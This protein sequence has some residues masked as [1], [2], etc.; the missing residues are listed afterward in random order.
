MSKTKSKTTEAER[1][2][3]VLSWFDG[4]DLAGLPEGESVEVEFYSYRVAV[5]KTEPSKWA[6]KSTLY[7]ITRS[8]QQKSWRRS[9]LGTTEG[10]GDR[11]TIRAAL[12]RFIN[13]REEIIRRREERTAAKRKARA[14]FENPYKPGNFLYSHWG[15]D[16]TNIEFYQVLEVRPTS[17]KIREVCQGREDTGWAQ[18][19]CW[20]V[21]N[22]FTERSEEKWVTIQIAKNGQHHIVSPD[23]DCSDLYLYDGRPKYWSSYA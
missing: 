12:E 10:R 6:P 2:A 14:E 9:A 8:P 4:L 21:P 15:Y 22:D 3:E 23:Y 20:P 19:N 13:K 17:L 1:R 5:Y 18:G 11:E 16:Q 7:L